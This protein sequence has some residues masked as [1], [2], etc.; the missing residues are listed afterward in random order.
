MLKY[1]LEVDD[2][3]VSIFI[4]D[5]DINI[6][7]NLDEAKQKGRISLVGPYSA[8]IHQAQT[9]I[10]GSKK[11]IEVYCKNNYLFAMNNDGTGHDGSTGYTIPNKVADAMRQINGFRVPQNQIID[12]VQKEGILVTNKM[13]RIMKAVF[14]YIHG[15]NRRT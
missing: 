10:P 15:I 11:H 3:I 1:L 13:E 7:Q 8:N 4:D 14:D 12:S 5:V 2:Y 6:K 9:H